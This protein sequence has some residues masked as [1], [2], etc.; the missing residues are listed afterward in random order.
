MRKTWWRLETFFLKAFD[1]TQPR[2][3]DELEELADHVNA[4]KNMMT[5]KHGFSPMQHVF[6]CDIRLPG[7]S[8]ANSTYL[9]GM[10]EYHPNDACL[11]STEILLAARWAMVEMDNVDKL[12]RATEHSSRPQPEF[13]LGDYVYCWRVSKESEKYGVWKG[14]ARIIGKIDNSKLWIARGNKVLR[15]SPLQLQTVSEE[16]EA[17]LRF[18]PPEALKPAGRG[19]N[20]GARTFIV[21]TKEGSPPS[22]PLAQSQPEQ[23]AGDM[24]I[25]E[26]ERADERMAGDED[27]SEVNEESTKDESQSRSLD[28]DQALDMDVERTEADAPNAVMHKFVRAHQVSRRGPMVQFERNL[29]ENDSE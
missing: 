16:H 10:T 17:A 7:I 23:V 27:H 18:V 12:K 15:C 19:A 29:T 26:E 21:I 13:D 4:A 9:Q 8:H 5:R 2:T 11:R 20:K 6:G 14:P 3:K 24:E 25:D 1:E 28:L 22:P